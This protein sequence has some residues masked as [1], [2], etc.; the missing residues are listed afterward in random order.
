MFQHLSL[1]ISFNIHMDNYIFKHPN[2]FKGPADLLH[3]GLTTPLYLMIAR[4]ILL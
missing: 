1:E 4:R 3:L 2:E